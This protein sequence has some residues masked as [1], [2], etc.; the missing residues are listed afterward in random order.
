MSPERRSRGSS[1]S[2]GDLERL[3]DEMFYW[4]PADAARTEVDFLLRKGSQFIAI[5]VKSSTGRVRPEQARFLAAVKALGGL[6]GVAR[7][8]EDARKIILAR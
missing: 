4:A 5:E 1:A 2:Y 3:F 7:S 8:V 6:A